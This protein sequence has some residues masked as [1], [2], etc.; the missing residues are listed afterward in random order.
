M[1]RF[2][3]SMSLQEGGSG[4]GPGTFTD[5]DELMSTYRAEFTHGRLKISFTV[6]PN[7]LTSR[8]EKVVFQN[9]SLKI[10]LFSTSFLHPQPRL[11]RA[12]GQTGEVRYLLCPTT[13]GSL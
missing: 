11:S 13:I 6:L 12:T 4:S 9:C 3:E 7:M 8:Q 10:G 5:L 1:N 2:E